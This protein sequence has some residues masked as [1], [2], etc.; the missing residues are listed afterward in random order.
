MLSFLKDRTFSKTWKM[1]GRVGTGHM[2][3]QA[4]SFG[5]VTLGEGCSILYGVHRVRRTDSEWGAMAGKWGLM[6]TGTRCPD[7][8]IH[9]T[10]MLGFAWEDHSIPTYLC[11]MAPIDK[12]TLARSWGP[13][14][15]VP[16]PPELFP[17]WLVHRFPR[18][19][20]SD[21]MGLT[22]I[23]G[24]WG[25]TRGRFGKKEPEVLLMLLVDGGRTPRC[26]QGCPSPSLPAFQSF[27]G[28]AA[29][30]PSGGYVTIWSVSQILC[31]PYKVWFRGKNLQP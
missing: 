4:G 3:L 27:L 6:G 8:Q 16:C 12:H 11:V 20:K 9:R 17:H 14:S 7:T 1:W 24:N 10:A 29:S 13:G 31:D 23:V 15:K 22:L 25:S 28:S 2:L 18:G 19:T 5:W 26:P 30:V 21:A